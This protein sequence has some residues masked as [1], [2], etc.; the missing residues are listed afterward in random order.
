M[1]SMLVNA[2]TPEGIEVVCE[3]CCPAH[4]KSLR[5]GRRRARQALKQTLKR[6]EER[7]YRREAERD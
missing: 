5:P 6:R 2:K 1:A 4:G 3:G 7:A